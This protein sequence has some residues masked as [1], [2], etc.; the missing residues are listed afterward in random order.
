MPIIMGTWYMIHGTMK[1]IRGGLFIRACRGFRSTSCSRPLKLFVSR[2]TSSPQHPICTGTDG[3]F[4]F[5]GSASDMFVKFLHEGPSAYHAWC[6]P[7]VLRPHRCRAFAEAWCH[8]QS[9]GRG[10]RIIFSINLTRTCMDVWIYIY[11]YAYIYICIHASISFQEYAF[12]E[13]MSNIA[14]QL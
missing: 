12:V 2:V 11:M 13:S 4:E 1:L 9:S 6:S 10:P 14:F 7:H 5:C 8:R 3:L